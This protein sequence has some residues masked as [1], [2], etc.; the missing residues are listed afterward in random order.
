MKPNQILIVEDE[1]LIADTIERYLTR[2]GYWVMGS[3]ISCEEAETLY[4]R[5]TPD[6]AL[7]DIRLSGSRTGIDF[8]HF[9]RKQARPAPF[10]Y[11]TSQLDRR[12]IVSTIQNM[13]AP[14]FAPSGEVW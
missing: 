9:I 2:Q 10:I 1:I 12:S 3:A 13:T 5:Q 14:F 6:L 4:L 11:L 7:L 8:A